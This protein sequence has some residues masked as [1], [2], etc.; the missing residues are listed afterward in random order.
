[1]VDCV[2]ELLQRRHVMDSIHFGR[3]LAHVAVAGAPHPFLLRG[4]PQHA[5]GVPLD[6]ID[7]IDPGIVVVV[8][9]IAQHDHGGPA[10]NRIQMLTTKG[11]QGGAEIGGIV[12][13]RDTLQHAADGLLWPLP[14][15]VLGDV[16]HVV[17]KG[18]RA[19]M[20]QHV[21]QLVHQGQHKRCMRPHRG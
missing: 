5:P 11:R 18:E 10:I 3:I 7:A 6:G 15:E 20:R 9:A 4:K 21:L 2:R 12:A 19:R 14:G 13:G 16:V 1:M 8:A 17:D